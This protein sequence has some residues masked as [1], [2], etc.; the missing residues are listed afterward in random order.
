MTPTEEEPMN[1]LNGNGNGELLLE[2]NIVNICFNTNDNFMDA[3][4][5]GTQEQLPP[6]GD[7][8]VSNEFSDNLSILLGDG[9]FTQAAESPVTVGDRPASVAVD[10]LSDI[11]LEINTH[12]ILN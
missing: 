12:N 2:R 6:T 11:A 8:A 10:T 5:S 3:E 4:L 1:E 9:A 7:L